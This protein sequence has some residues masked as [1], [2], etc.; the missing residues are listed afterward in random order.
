MNDALP[1]YRV[2]VLWLG[3]ALFVVSLAGCIGMI[4]LASQYPDEPV[5]VGSERLLKMPATHQPSSQ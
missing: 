3:I 1:W 2:P 4:V 5:A